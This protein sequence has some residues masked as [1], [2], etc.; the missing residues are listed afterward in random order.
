MRK[1]IAYCFYLYTILCGSTVSF[2]QFEPPA[3]QP[4]TSAMH[5][6][7]SAFIDWV[8]SCTVVRGLQ[9][10][11]NPGGGYASAGDSSQVFGMAGSNGV[12]SLGDGGSAICN[13]S[14]QVSNGPGY[15]FAVFENGFD[16]FF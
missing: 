16:D 6:D 7:S 5:K 9:D 8:T 15:D 4:G 1:S 13:F 3:G 12:A 10:I 2:A 11:S 14:T